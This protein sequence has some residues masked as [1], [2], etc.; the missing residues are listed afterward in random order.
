MPVK[1][2]TVTQRWIIDGTPDDAHN[3]EDVPVDISVDFNA[4]AARLG[5]RALRNKTGR[6]SYLKGAVIVRRAQFER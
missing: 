2:G 4:L 5:R 6:A 1:N 3:V